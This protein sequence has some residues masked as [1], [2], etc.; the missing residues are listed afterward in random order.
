ML[1]IPYVSPRVTADSSAVRILIRE[2]RSYREIYEHPVSDNVKNIL[3]AGVVRFK[4]CRYTLVVELSLERAVSH[5]VE[6]YI[7]KAHVDKI[8]E[9]FFDYV[10]CRGMSWVKRRSSVELSVKPCAVGRAE[11]GVIVGIACVVYL[12]ALH[13]LFRIVPAGEWSIVNSRSLSILMAVLYK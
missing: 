1:D 7:F 10:S 6:L 5:E 2:Q 8:G 12:T 9:H 11:C 4:T 3:H 13:V